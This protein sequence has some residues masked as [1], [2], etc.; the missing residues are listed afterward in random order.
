[1]L[2]RSSADIKTMF[3]TYGYYQGKN[4]EKDYVK[5]GKEIMSI[6]TKMTPGNGIIEGYTVFE[7]INNSPIFYI[8]VDEDWKQKV[9]PTRI[10][11]GFEHSKN[12][13]FQFN[14]VSKG[15]YMDKIID[16]KDNY[17]DKYQFHIGSILIGDLTDEK[18]NSQSDNVTMMVV[19]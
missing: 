12:K 7:V 11:Y 5:S 9:N 2:F 19:K 3:Y 6:S 13:T 16:D 17:D 14:E 15:I 10:F 8:F 1:M 18:I 4:F